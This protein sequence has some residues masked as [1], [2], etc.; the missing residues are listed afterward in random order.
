[1]KEQKP[2]THK[3]KA[4]KLKLK[5]SLACF[6]FFML[7]IFVMLL[8]SMNGILLSLAVISHISGMYLLATSGYAKRYC[9]NWVHCRNQSGP[10]SFNYSDPIFRS[11]HRHHSR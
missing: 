2:N 8:T 9:C 4:S 5:A 6:G 7:M 3:E 11:H 10:Y 1:M